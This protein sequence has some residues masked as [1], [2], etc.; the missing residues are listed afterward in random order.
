MFTFWQIVAA[1]AIAII[2]G[3]VGGVVGINVAT[4]RT[5]PYFLEFNER[6]SA[7]EN[8]RREW[9]IKYNALEGVYRQLIKW[10][11]E[12]IGIF[13]RIEFRYPEPPHRDKSA[14]D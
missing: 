9:R 8:E 6:I 13:E 1:I 11:D 14:A 12:V 10:S 2:G 7:L 5:V 4:R 3:F